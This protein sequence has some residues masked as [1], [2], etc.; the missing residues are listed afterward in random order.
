MKTLR[1]ELGYKQL[2]ILDHALN[3][4]I[5]RPHATQSDVNDENELL[6]RVNDNIKI[7]KGR[8]QHGEKQK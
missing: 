3:Y 5:N 6:N 8:K 7:L 2:M 4:Y 1:V